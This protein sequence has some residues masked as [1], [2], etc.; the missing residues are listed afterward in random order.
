MD[1]NLVKSILEFS[2]PIR[3]Q[4]RVI[5][6]NSLLSVKSVTIGLLVLLFSQI[7]SGSKFFSDNNESVI[8][9]VVDVG[10]DSNNNLP[11]VILQD[12]ETNRA[13]PIWIG[14]SEARAIKLELQGQTAPR[15][16][17]H[18]L[19]KSILRKTG[20]VFQKILVN[21]LK[22]GTYYAKIY[23]SSEGD[24]F[25]FDSRPSD[26][27]ALALRFRKPIMV[28]RSLMED[29]NTFDLK[30]IKR[31]AVQKVKGITVQDITAELMVALKLEGQEG[32]L[33]SNI[34]KSQSSGL[35][36]GDIIFSVN[37][38]SIRNISDFRDQIA[39]LTES[40]F[41]LGVQREGR[42]ISVDLILQ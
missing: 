2:K 27:I 37:S 23:L 8:V 19:L 6:R 32:V 12:N 22:G 20:I 36:R 30:K 33:V 34:E 35:K 42:K 31:P 17:T 5:M 10:F 3:K 39:G 25:Q 14:I 18:D 4:K 13:I 7:G 26:A 11:V 9:E 41:K 15:P 1:S 16:M 21:D 40:L 24:E 28:S 29:D 38:K